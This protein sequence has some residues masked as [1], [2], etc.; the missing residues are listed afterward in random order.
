MINI[1][2]K[3]K[4]LVVTLLSI[5]FYLSYLFMLGHLSVLPELICFFWYINKSS[6]GF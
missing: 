4:R 2:R 5:P 1:S 3:E 6:E